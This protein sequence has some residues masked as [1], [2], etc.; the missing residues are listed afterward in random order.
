MFVLTKRKTLFYWN[1]VV[2]LAILVLYPMFGG[3]MM[4]FVLQS[5]SD[6]GSMLLF[7]KEMIP[8]VR[9]VQVS[10]QVLLLCLPVLLLAGLHTGDRG[11]FS[12]RNRE[13]LGLR[14]RISWPGMF[15]AVSGVVLL[16]P[17]IYAMMEM[18][19]YVL[20][21]LGE[22][23][24][25]LLENQEQLERYIMMLAGADSLSEFLVAGFV[26]AV[27]PAFCE[28]LF[29]RGY[30]Q[31]NYILSLSPFAGI[32]LTGI[33]FG[34]FHLSPANLLPLACM[35]WYLGYVYYKTENLLVPV[36]VHF[37]NNML[38]LVIV[39]VQRNS[40]ET[41]Q[42]VDVTNETVGWIVLS[43]GL[44]LLLFA[45]VL[46]RFNRL[47]SPGDPADADTRSSL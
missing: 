33:V 27:I 45:L 32:L 38:S 1:S 34:L 39:Q 7:Q 19:G 8:A 3:V 6:E 12:G 35:G 2:L 43:V 11:P 20:S 18:I 28:E 26:I 16:Q 47:F 31:K 40:S 30:V 37:C 17:P 25:A 15:F 23:G 41:F 14:K 24:S 10:G 46:R 22:F 29:F 5:G 21:H 13:F 9:I 44:S 42:V 36:A 4:S